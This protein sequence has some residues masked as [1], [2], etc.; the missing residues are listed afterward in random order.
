MASYLAFSASVTTHGT[1]RCSGTPLAF[2]LRAKSPSTILASGVTRPLALAL[3]PPVAH[4]SLI[5]P[6]T[7]SR[8]DSGEGPVRAGSAWYGAAGD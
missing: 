1:V 7:E 3:P 6:A 5:E 8:A 4:G 2:P